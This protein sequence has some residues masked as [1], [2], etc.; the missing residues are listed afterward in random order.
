MITEDY[1]S[2]EVAKLLKEKGFPQEYDKF[3]ANVYNEEDYER[4]YE[5][6][7]MVLQTELVKS[8]TLCNYPAGISGPKCYAPTY[9]EVLEWLRENYNIYIMVEPHSFVQN[10][11][12]NYE[13]NYWFKGH[14]YES[15]STKNH[16]LEGKVWDKY[17]DATNAIID[18]CITTLI[19]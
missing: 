16:P 1:V 18:Y 4:E 5:V 12:V 6:Q 11:A 15:Y 10:K 19:D 17:K 14:Y 7:R 13:A 9:E 3:N 2:F 8:G